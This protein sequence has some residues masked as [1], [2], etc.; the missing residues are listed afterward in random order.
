MYKN[1]DGYIYIDFFSFDKKAHYRK[2]IKRSKIFKKK[3]E[4]YSFIENIDEYK[5]CLS[6]DTFNTTDKKEILVTIDKEIFIQKIQS[7]FNSENDIMDQFIKDAKR[8]KFYL[9]NTLLNDDNYDLFFAYLD[10]KYDNKQRNIILMLCTQAIFAYPFEIIQNSLTDK[11]LS[12][13]S[14][15]EKNKNDLL[16]IKIIINSEGVRFD[17]SKKMRIF[18]FDDYSNDITL[19]YVN[20]K[21]EF[22][23]DFDKFILMKIYIEN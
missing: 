19:N 5:N 23:L 8:S 18:R 15:H 6:L 12:E 3:N 7:G 4:D 2:K 11:Y 16:K 14:I 13:I 10:N 20:I 1:I 9:N 21:L 17:I 22:N